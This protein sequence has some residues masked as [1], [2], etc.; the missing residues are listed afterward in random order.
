MRLHTLGGLSID[1]D[2]TDTPGAAASRRRPLA[3][4]AVLAVAGARGVSR[5]Q[6]CAL[7]WP[8]SDAD[9]ARNA[10]NQ[11]LHAVRHGVKQPALVLGTTELRLD[12]ALLTS[13]VGDLEAALAAG[14]R[15]R[16]AALYAGPFLDGVHL[17]GA[18]EFTRWAER[19]RD[20]IAHR[21]RAAL[22]AL[23]ADATA[24]GDHAAAAG[25]W[26]RLA[27]LDPAD[28]RA[29][30]GLMGA[31]AAAGDRAG[32][33]Q[34][35]RVHE[36]FVRAEL[37]AAPDPAVCALAA[38]LRTPAVAGDVTSPNDDA[39]AAPPPHAPPVGAESVAAIEPADSAGPTEGA[40]VYTPNAVPALPSAAANV[41]VP[42]HPANRRHRPRI[43]AQLAL[44]ALLGVAVAGAFRTSRERAGKAGHGAPPNRI[45]VFPFA[46]SGGP[47]YA[48]L[49]EGLADVVSVQ[50]NGA[51][52]VRTVEPQ[53]VLHALGTDAAAPLAPERG[54]DVAAALG[55]G[56][57][58]LGEAVALGPRLRISA[59]LYD[60]AGHA[61]SRA[62]ADGTPAD[63]A[64]VV[65]RLTSGLLAGTFGA[66]GEQ[67]TR[68]AALTTRSLP[69]LKAYLEGEQEMRAGRYGTAAD[70][71]QRAVTEDSAFA[72]AYYRL[73][74]AAEWAPWAQ[75][76]APQAA[77][78]VRY[79]DR[80][81]ERDRQLLRATLARHRGALDE[82]ARQY[83]VLL[84]VYPDD[85]EAWYQLGEIEFHDG[86]LRGR[87]LGDA[88]EPFTRF[89]RY[90]PD[91]GEALVHLL[92]IAAKEG[93]RGETDTLA[94]RLLAHEGGAPNVELR[95]FHAFAVGDRAAQE[96]ALGA[97]AQAGDEA[98]LTAMRHVAVFTEDLAG[99]ARIADLLTDASRGPDYRVQGYV[100]AADLALARGRWRDAAAALGPHPGLDPAWGAELEGTLAALPFLDRPR[101]E[102]A[103]LRARL[104]R[105]AHPAGRP[106][107]SLFGGVD[108]RVG[109]YASA[110]LSVRLGDLPA[111]ERDAAALD[112]EAHRAPDPP[113]DAALVRALA[114]SVRADVA[115]AR[116]RPADA[117]AQL[118]GGRLE[119]GLGYVS[120]V[121]GC[122]AYDRYARAEA[123]QALGRDDEA[124]RWY[125][126]L[127]EAAVH[128]LVFLA[129]AHLRQAEIYDRRGDAGRAAAHYRRFVELW[130]DADP[131]LQPAVA[132]AGARRR[133]IA[134]AGPRR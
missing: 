93:R 103:A 113:A 66:P 101:G 69:A 133:A 46:V 68:T 112:R 36:A 12:P 114:A 111:A 102:L 71:F 117:L 11:L 32:A 76:G 35:A 53:V 13:D 91:D 33:L 57:F 65:D 83:R 90:R 82:A 88:W 98:V 45:A 127:G 15:E 48:Y 52:D 124:L 104:A 129:P 74:V 58:V 17:T 78:A 96:R 54:R 26:R 123:L 47:A 89:L 79:M 87:P 81:P 50:L 64:A 61:T 110:L 1:A 99:A 70:A 51:G 84:T 9:R 63:L 44:V 56:Q 5:D 97:L 105:V 7:F 92:R 21:V 107:A 77:R 128:E 85:A 120:N 20:R 30:L 115:R 132:A 94:A 41:P 73:S 37:D 121:L 72:L 42:A 134:A 38:R 86:P 109:P 31:L 59:A 14:E 122:Q 27:E 118:D 22:H 6:L 75:A 67:L 25:W 49:R 131:E 4:L 34:H 108:A 28:G 2:G 29:A 24:R 3:L 116:G 19:E 23:A 16:A 95:A 100:A 130:H 80:L 55:A 126:T 60:A 10:L 43:L 106:Y 62:T 39:P 18:P 40:P 8:E 125:A 119:L